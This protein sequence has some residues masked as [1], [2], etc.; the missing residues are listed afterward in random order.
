M[1][2]TAAKF[3]LAD[4]SRA[5]KAAKAQGAEVVELRPD[6][7]ITIRLALNKHE[8]K[9]EPKPNIRDFKL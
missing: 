4:I 5:A 3:T 8:A 7:T 2:R 1:S 6:G 9:P